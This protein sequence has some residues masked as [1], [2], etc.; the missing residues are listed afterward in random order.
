M[1]MIDWSVGCTVKMLKE[2]RF[3][4]MNQKK[5]HAFNYLE[6]RVNK[7]ISFDCFCLVCCVFKFN[8]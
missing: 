8:I 3:C 6:Y 4:F 2:A 1:E 5:R 7:A